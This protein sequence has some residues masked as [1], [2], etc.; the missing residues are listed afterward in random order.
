MFCCG[1]LKYLQKVIQ[2][3]QGEF[4]RS[5]YSFFAVYDS[6]TEAED[7]PP[8]PAK[9]FSSIDNSFNVM[10]RNYFSVPLFP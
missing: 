9:G 10:T 3:I 2:E 8:R 6:S 1:S 5:N 4:I 7:L